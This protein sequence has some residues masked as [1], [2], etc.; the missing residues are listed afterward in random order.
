MK[1]TAVLLLITLIVRIPVFSSE[2]NG[3][4]SI[5]FDKTAVKAGDYFEAVIKVEN[6][7]AEF[8]VVP[9]HFNS[10]VVKVADNNGIPV[11]SGIKTAAEVHN[12]SIGLTPLQA[13]SGNS[14][15]WNG[16][17]FDNPL[18]PEIDNEGG[19]CRLM[20]LNAT[21]KNIVSETL[22]S[23][24]FLAVDVGD[25]DIRF[26][27]SKDKP[28]D[29]TAENGAKYIYKNYENPFDSSVSL[30]FSSVAIQKLIV[31][32]PN[33]IKK[34][35]N[36]ISGEN[37]DCVS[38]IAAYDQNTMVGLSIKNISAQVNGSDI[39]ECDIGTSEN[40]IKHFLLN[41]LVNIMPLSGAAEVN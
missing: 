30:D 41:D 11:L 19:F 27:T 33:I 5:T 39:H 10:S 24:K 32:N 20:F 16:A 36:N 31:R 4:I 28:H 26:A 35:I 37:L 18:Y 17:I 9:I 1:I 14:S 38:V 7:K 21:S 13:L 6:I 8:I 23:I 22:I 29:I 2:E 25:T 3:K 40:E 15:Y 34:T 12:G